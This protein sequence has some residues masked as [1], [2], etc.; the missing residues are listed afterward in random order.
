MTG[1]GWADEVQ[2]SAREPPDFKDLPPA[3]AA[4]CR[5]K[6]S[7]VCGRPLQHLISVKKNSFLHFK[8]RAWNGETG[9]NKQQTGRSAEVVFTRASLQRASDPVTV[10][11]NR[12]G[13]LKLCLTEILKPREVS[14]SL[15][16]SEDV[17][18][19]IYVLNRELSGGKT[20][21]S[22]D[23]SGTKHESL[24]APRRPSRPL[25]GF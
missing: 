18:L 11:K 21:L 10:Q 25:S 15:T 4:G 16:E 2:G 5:R 22:P 1:W 20:S 23:Y 12:K 17:T 19:C 7:E 3:S 24:R 9:R 8:L 14:F 6:P 13:E